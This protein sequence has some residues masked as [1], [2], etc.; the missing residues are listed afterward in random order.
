MISVITLILYTIIHEP[1][2]VQ[3][4]YTTAV[5][6]STS[7][8]C[9]SLILGGNFHICGMLGRGCVLAGTLRIRPLLLSLG[10]PDLPQRQSPC[11]K[12]QSLL[13]IPVLWPISIPVPLVAH[14]NGQA[15]LGCHGNTAVLPTNQPVIS[16]YQSPESLHQ[17]TRK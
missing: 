14:R 7:S 6:P 9:D 8:Y 5:D 3:I 15:V 11:P 2:S 16:E 10:R 17:P 4:L 12:G 13:R 1:N